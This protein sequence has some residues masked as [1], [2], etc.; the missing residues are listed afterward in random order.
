MKGNYD[1]IM[2]LTEL[3]LDVSA[4]DVS[5]IISFSVHN[6]SIFIYVLFRR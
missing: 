1:V 6:Q 4:H 3:G 5:T 2:K